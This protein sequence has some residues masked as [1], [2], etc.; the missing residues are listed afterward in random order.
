VTFLKNHK[1][2]REVPLIEIATLKRG[3]DLPI[4]NRAD[5][6]VPI[7]AANGQNG[8]HNE[9]KASGPG[10]VTGRSGTIGK[11]H[12]VEGDYWPLNTS[13]Y[14]TDFHG[15][16]PKWVYYMLQAFK[17]ERFVEG[18][19]V[20]TLNRNL[21]H[22]EK[23]PLPPLPEQIRIAAILD[24]ADS[25]RRKNQQAIQFADQFLR[26]VF[27]DMFGDPV[28][29]PKGWN[30]KPLGEIV[31]N[32]DGRR[33]PVKASDRAVTN[34][35]YRYYG[36]SGIID[37]VDDYIFDERTLLIG[38]DG[39]NLLARST[40]IAFIVEGKYWVNNHAHVLA[41]NGNLPLE[42]LMYSINMRSIAAYVTGSAQP[43]LNQ[44]ML[45]KIPIQ[46]PNQQILDKFV[47]LIGIASNL[48]AKFS[49]IPNEILF[50]SLSQK[51]FAG[52][53]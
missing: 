17:L 8:T 15:N 44:E 2:Y 48:K 39:A 24:K 22:G 49:I 35:K 30:I 19:G 16:H 14:V 41:E 9:V 36:A 18:A 51:A 4:Q 29:N 21:V 23:I 34:A 45:N 20:P 31:K 43:K 52:E 12:Y 27:L 3:Y 37:H 1:G 50:N 38:E 11:V 28:T 7:F 53:L 13:L 33:I 10:V 26:A 47:K 42:Y 46:I 32:L 6:N 40:P 5:G 25:L